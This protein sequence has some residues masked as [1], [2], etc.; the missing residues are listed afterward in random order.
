MEDDTIKELQLRLLYLALRYPPT[1]LPLPC[2]DS[3]RVSAISHLAPQTQNITSASPGDGLNLAVINCE[4][5]AARKIGDQEHSRVKRQRVEDMDSDEDPYTMNMPRS[6]GV[7]VE[8]TNGLP[9]TIKLEEGTSGESKSRKRQKKE[10]DVGPADHAHQEYAKKE[11]DPRSNPYLAHMYE[12]K[13][14]DEGDVGYNGY[15]NGYGKGTSRTNGVSDSSTLARLPRHKTTAAMATNAENGPNNP[16][17]GQPLSKQYFNILKTRR[18]LPVHQQ[19]DEFLKMYQKSQF[20]VRAR[21]AVDGFPCPD[22]K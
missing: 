16:F 2:I 18:N 6:G 3:N 9:T 10:E 15:S 21:S 14:E 7:K 8:Q 5:M 12:E 19:R 20:L 4:Q 11:K 1:I 13:E 17:S 22:K